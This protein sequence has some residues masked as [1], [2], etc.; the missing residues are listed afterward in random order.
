[1]KK[2]VRKAFKILKQSIN[3]TKVDF[4]D[5]FTSSYTFQFSTYI[6]S[7]YFQEYNNFLWGLNMSRSTK[8]CQIA[9]KK[10]VEKLF[11]MIDRFIIYLMLTQN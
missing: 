11:K 10:Y 1:M 5:Y 4:A 8:Q 7:Y 2:K 3:S 9:A 6:L